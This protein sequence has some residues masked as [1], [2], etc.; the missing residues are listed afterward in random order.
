MTRR[1]R[2]VQQG[3]ISSSI[4]NGLPPPESQLH[5]HL[6]LLSLWALLKFLV[7]L[8]IASIRAS[9]SSKM[10][11][12]AV[13][14]PRMGREMNTGGAMYF[15]MPI[16]AA[17]VPAASGGGVRCLL[18]SCS[19]LTSHPSSCGHGR[20]GGFAIQFLSS[21]ASLHV[22]IL[23]S[24]GTVASFEVVAFA[25]SMIIIIGKA[26][27]PWPIGQERSWLDWC[28]CCQISCSCGW[29]WSLLFDYQLDAVRVLRD[30]IDLLNF[31]IFYCHRI[32]ESVEVLLGRVGLVHGA[33]VCLPA[34]ARHLPTDVWHV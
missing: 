8:L 23:A 21:V 14:P 25:E 30:G 31:W 11:S 9:G 24:E 28:R 32:D 17:A 13:T 4:A 26:L 33:K 27:A 20:G 2:H 18:G 5:T 29:T 12:K 7:A 16:A 10:H 15:W 1:W 19:S 22:Q 3:L 6:G 34:I